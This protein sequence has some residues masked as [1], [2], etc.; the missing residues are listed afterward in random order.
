MPQKGKNS[1]VFSNTRR[2]TAGLRGRA[3]VGEVSAAKEPYLFLAA[4]AAGPPIPP[5][6]PLRLAASSVR[7]PMATSGE[8]LTARQ[9]G[10][11]GGSARLAAAGRAPR[12]GRGW[13]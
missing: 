6:A 9:A 11:G 5:L 7:V 12:G 13:R 10:P 1:D 2:K 4:P 8:A 3:R